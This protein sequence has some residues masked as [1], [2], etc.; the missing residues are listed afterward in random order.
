MWPPTVS[1]VKIKEGKSKIE[2]VVPYTKPL[3]IACLLLPFL[4]TT[5]LS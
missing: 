2:P 4:N 5:R 3:K 1:P